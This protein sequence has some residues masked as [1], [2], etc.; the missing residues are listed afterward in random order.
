MLEEECH[1]NFAFT[2][3]HAGEMPILRF[4]RV[5]VAKVGGEGRVPG[6]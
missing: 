3:V 2:M 6:A 1:R 5:E 4:D